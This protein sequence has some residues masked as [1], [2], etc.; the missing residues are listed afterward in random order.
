MRFGEMQRQHP[1]LEVVLNVGVK[2]LNRDVVEGQTVLFNCGRCI[3]TGS[4]CSQ[5]SSVST[6]I[7]AL[8]VV[9]SALFQ[10]SRVP[11]GRFVEL[12]GRVRQ[13]EVGLNSEVYCHLSLGN[14]HGY[15]NGYGDL[16]KYAKQN[17]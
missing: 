16:K 6:G 15:G 14:F 12:L 10:R 2:A 4:N 11:I 8:V 7:V 3:S 5:R 13:I 9:L 17:G 1:H